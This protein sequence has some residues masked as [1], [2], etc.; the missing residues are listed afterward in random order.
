[1]KVAAIILAG[2]ASRRMGTPKALLDFR[3][4][5]FLDRLIRIFGE[6]CDSVTVVLG[7]DRSIQARISR[8]NL[9]NFVVNPDYEKGQLSSLQCGLQAVPGDADAV[10]F[11][12]V[13][14]PAVELC[15]V[16]KMLAAMSTGKRFVVPRWDERHGHPVLFSACMISEFLKLPAEAEARTV[17]RSNISCTTYVDVNDPG[18]VRDVDNPEAYAELLAVVARAE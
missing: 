3:G 11:T 18:I 12:P 16:A 7:H 5:T 2:G 9:A 10:L 17:V 1:V 13:D 14:C 8:G 6:T 15:T 4:E